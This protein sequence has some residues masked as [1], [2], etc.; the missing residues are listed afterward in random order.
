MTETVFRKTYLAVKQDL[1]V[2]LR[3]RGES[4]GPLSVNRLHEQLRNCESLTK[5]Y[6]KSVRD[7]KNKTSKKNRVAEFR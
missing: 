7:P 2:W 5:E 1:D 4:A 3:E 6:L